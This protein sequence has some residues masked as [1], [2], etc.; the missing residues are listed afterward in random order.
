MRSLTHTKFINNSIINFRAKLE[1]EQKAFHL[2]NKNLFFEKFKTQFCITF[3]YI[4]STSVWPLIIMDYFF[5][6]IEIT[7]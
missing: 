2:M 6:N 5:K 1:I 4:V 7:Y 3:H